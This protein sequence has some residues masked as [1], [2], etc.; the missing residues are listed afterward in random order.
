MPIQRFYV[1]YTALC[2]Y[3]QLGRRYDTFR[4]CF[5]F[6]LVIKAGKAG[7]IVFAGVEYARI[8]PVN[9]V[10]IPHPIKL[11]IITKTLPLC[12]L[13]HSYR[14]FQGIGGRYVRAV[15]K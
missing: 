1:E 10:R 15:G 8:P 4:Q 6:K 5:V 12:P 14:E 7:I 2:R 13:R 3:A 11:N 9:A